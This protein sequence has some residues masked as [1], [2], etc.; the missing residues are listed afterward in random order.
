MCFPKQNTALALHG[1][2]KVS[3]KNFKLDHGFKI[4]ARF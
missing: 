2:N 3:I 1:S 4:T